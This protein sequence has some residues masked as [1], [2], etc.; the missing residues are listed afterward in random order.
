MKKNHILIISIIIILITGI[1]FFVK[2]KSSGQVTLAMTYIPNV[3]FAPWY[4]AKE[5]GFYRKEGLDVVFDYRMD[6][7]ALQL[8]ATGKMDYAIAGG[9][10]VLVARAQEIPVVYILSLYAKFPPSILAKTESGIKT[11]Q[12]L[13]GKQIGLPLYGTNL[14]AVNAILKRAGVEAKD[15]KL[16]DIGYTQI[17]SLAED[18]VDAVVGFANNEPVKLKAMG[19]EVNEIH[20]WDYFSLVGHGLITGEKKIASDSDEVKRLVRASLKG[21][22]YALAHPEETFEICLKYLPELGEEQKEQE[23]EVL[24]RSMAL[25]ENDYTREHGVGYSDPR[26]WED[27]QRL[28]M[29]LGIIQK[30]TPVE[31]VLNLSF[32]P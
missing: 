4:V 31:K 18:K 22:E 8:V 6:I 14:L 30:E 5:K 27:S 2:P 16:V 26:D 19:Y 21:L 13:R 7:D 17:Q 3:Q 10:Q 11:P 24:K 15:V 1:I 9:D 20:S 28:M 23:K 29:E 12:D 25:W 32:L